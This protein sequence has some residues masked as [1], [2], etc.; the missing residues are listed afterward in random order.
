MR[1]TSD[2]HGRRRLA[3]T[4]HGEDQVPAGPGPFVVLI[5]LGTLQQGN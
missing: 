5:N 4:A 1:G 3:G 2:V